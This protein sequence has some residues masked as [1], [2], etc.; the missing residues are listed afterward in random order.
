MFDAPYVY[1]AL[2]FF[3]NHVIVPHLI[4]RH[5]AFASRDHTKVVWELYNTKKGK[6][7][8]YSHIFLFNPVMVRSSIRRTSAYFICSASLFIFL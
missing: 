7:E 1:S 5:E 4:V 6:N 8:F 2:L 3:K